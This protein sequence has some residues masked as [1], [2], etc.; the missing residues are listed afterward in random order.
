MTDVTVTF[1]RME[2]IAVKETLER[3]PLFEGRS[4][5]RNIINAELRRRG[6][7]NPLRLQGCY[8]SHLARCIVAVDP[9][10]V[11]LRGKITR[12]L[13]SSQSPPDSIVNGL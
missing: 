8:L 6:R 4:E 3:T 9:D 1:T 11:S 2:L 7:P 13:R 10:S 12:A 5:L